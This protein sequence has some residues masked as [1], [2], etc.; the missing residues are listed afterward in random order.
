MPSPSVKW[1]QSHTLAAF[2]LYTLLPFGRL[3]RGT[4]EVQQLAAWQGRTASSVAMKLGNFASLDPQILV[5]G[6]A[7]LSGASN[8]D[9]AFWAALQHNWDVVAEEAANAYSM[10]ALNH[11]VAADNPLIDVIEEMPFSG[12][13]GRMRRAWVQVR[14]NQARFRKSVLTSYNA[15]CCISG[16]QHEK[17]VIASHIVPW[18]MDSKNR[19]NPQNGLCLSALH[20]KAYDQG[21][22]TVMPDFTVRV[23]PALKAQQEENFMADALLRFDGLSIRL[24]ERFR[25][26]PEFLAFHARTYGFIA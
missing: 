14:I 23:A 10:L 11:G 5:S 7:G 1:T 2:H 6:R 22:I 18:R 20:D 3:H 4:P 12:E 21:F 16:L 17:L 26:E 13:E 24:P 19:L 9:R 15:T 25:P 8:Q